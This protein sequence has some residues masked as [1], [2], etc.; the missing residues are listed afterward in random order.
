MKK[1]EDTR[2]PGI[3]HDECVDCG[4]D[5]TFGEDRCRDCQREWEELQ[6]ELQWESYQ[7]F[8]WGSK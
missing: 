8:R 4:D 7:A 6:L 2:D 3:E 5:C 1:I